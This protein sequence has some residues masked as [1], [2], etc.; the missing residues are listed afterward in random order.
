[1]ILRFFGAFRSQ[2]LRAP[3][4]LFST[5]AVAFSLVGS[6]GNAFAEEPQLVG[7]WRATHAAATQYRDSYSGAYAPTSGSSFAYEFLQDGTY[8]FSGLLQVT[9]YGCTSSVFQE[10]SGRYRA[11][12][13]QISIEP[14]Q[15]FVRSQTCGGQPSQKQADLAVHIYTFRLESQGGAA[16]LVLNGTD[17]KTKPDF[18]RRER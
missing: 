4:P 15:G 13:G 11:Q 1:M 14:A 10:S 8:R 7:K 12:E 9:T 16:V 2:R 5:L 17:G 3:L 6:S 18:F